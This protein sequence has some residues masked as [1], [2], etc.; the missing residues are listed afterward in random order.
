[1]LVQGTSSSCNDDIQSSEV[2]KP[3]IPRKTFPL[4]LLL[5]SRPSSTLCMC[6][7]SP[8]CHFSIHCFHLFSIRT[9][10]LSLE[11]QADLFL[12]LSFKED[13]V[14]AYRNICVLSMMLK[15]CHLLSSLSSLVSLTSLLHAYC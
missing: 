15:S 6:Q 11:K 2:L 3:G 4:N 9:E 14:S 7:S 10:C 5:T 13:H 1:M 8:A 12:H